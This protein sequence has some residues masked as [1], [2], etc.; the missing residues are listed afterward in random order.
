MAG[1]GPIRPRIRSPHVI[2]INSASIS[3]QSDGIWLISGLCLA[4][5]QPRDMCVEHPST[6]P[7]V[8]GSHYCGPDAEGSSTG[9]PVLGPQSQG[10]LERY[11]LCSIGDL[12]GRFPGPFHDLRTTSGD[13]F[14]T[15]PGSIRGFPGAVSGL[16]RE[17]SK[18][19]KGSESGQITSDRDE[20]KTA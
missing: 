18:T 11:F 13:L 10:L 5:L 20:N 19:K 9:A 16:V 8:L 3:A 4:F 1:A 2:L 15:S 14:A 6:G 17:G 7:R 12:P